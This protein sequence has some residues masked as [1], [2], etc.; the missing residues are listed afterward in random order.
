MKKLISSLSYSVRNKAINICLLPFALMFSTVSITASA[1]TNGLW[2]KQFHALA[3]YYDS[4]CQGK[5][6]KLSDIN[7]NDSPEVKKVSSN[8]TIGNND[9]GVCTEYFAEYFGGELFIS[10]EENIT[11]YLKSDDGSQLFINGNLLINNDNTHDDSNE[12]N[13]SIT[14][15]VGWHFIEV[16]YFNSGGG[17]SLAVSYSSATISKQ[18]IPSSVL[19]PDGAYDPDD[20]GVSNY[21]DLDVDG[22]GLIE[23]STLAELD[24]VRNNLAGAALFGKSDGCGAA[25]IGFELTKDLDFDTSGDGVVGANDDY[26]NAGDGWLP[27]GRKSNSAFKAIFEGNSFTINNLNINRGQEDGVGFF[28]FARGGA[29][30]QNLDLTNTRVIGKN[31]VGALVGKADNTTFNNVFSTGHVSGSNDVGGLIGWANTVAITTVHHIGYISGFGERVGGIVGNLANN[32]SIE[33]AFNIGSVKGG[34]RVGGITGTSDSAI[35]DVYVAGYVNGDQ[36]VGGITSGISSAHLARSYVVAQVTGNFDTGAILG[37]IFAPDASISSSYWLTGIAESA[38]FY[39]RNVPITITEANLVDL[40]CPTNAGDNSCN[41]I[42]YADWD[43]STPIWQFGTNN[44]LPALM[45]NGTVYFLADFD[46]D[47]V[48]DQLDAFPSI[49]IGALLD[50]D[51][52]GIPDDCDANCLSSGLIADV[53]DDNDG[54]DDDSDAFPFDASEFTDNDSDGTGDNADLDDDNDGVNDDQDE[55]PLDAAESSDTDGDG[56]GDNAD[57]DDDNDGYIDSKDSA[58]LNS[59]LPGLT[60]IRQQSGDNADIRFAQAIANIGDV[61]GDGVNDLAISAHE[62]DSNGFDNSGS[63]HVMS[64]KTGQILYKIYGEGE[65]DKLAEAMISAPDMDGD[66]I[67]DFLVRRRGTNGDELESVELFSSKAGTS[68]FTIAIPNDLNVNKLA[69]IDDLNGDGIADILVTLPGF[70]NVQNNIGAVYIYSGADGSELSHIEGEGGYFGDEIAVLG[71]IND[72]L[73]ADFI[74]SAASF[75]GQNDREGRI[76]AYSGA[77]NQL[78]YQVGGQETNQEIGEEMVAIGDIDNDGINDFVYSNRTKLTVNGEERRFITFASGKDGNQIEQL[79]AGNYSLGGFADQLYSISDIDGDGSIDLVITDEGDD[80]SGSV[81]D[82]IFYSTSKKHIIG[83]INNKNILSRGSFAE[84]LLVIDDITGDN[85]SEIVVGDYLHDGQASNAG[86]IF[87]Y[88]FGDFVVDTDGDG[89]VNGDDADID[90]DGVTNFNDAYPYISLAG[91]TDSDLDGIP[92][93]CDSECQ[94]SGMVTDNYING[95]IYVDSSSSC[96]AANEVC[97]QSWQSPFRTLQDALVVANTNQQIWLAQGLY[98]PNESDNNVFNNDLVAFKLPSNVSLYGGFNAA[99][100]PTLLTEAD[101]HKF[102]TILSGDVDHLSSPDLTD[103]LGITQTVTDIIGDNASV[104]IFTAL[105]SQDYTIAGLTLTGVSRMQSNQYAL[106]ISSGNATVKNIDIIGSKSSINLRENINCQIEMNNINLI[107]ITTGSPLVKIFDTQCQKITISDLSTTNAYT[108]D[109]MF[110]VRGGDNNIEFN[111]ISVINENRS[112]ERLLYTTSDQSNLTVTINDSVFKNI[113]EVKSQN[114]L[115]V[116]NSIFMQTHGIEQAED[117]PLTVKHSS[118]INNKSTNDAGAISSTSS[119]NNLGFNLFVGN[120]GTKANNIY[121]VNDVNDLGYNLV[122]ANSL[123]GFVSQTGLSFVQAFDSATS[124]TS[125]LTIEQITEQTLADNGGNILT[126]LPTLQGPAVDVISESDCHQEFDIRGISR[127][128]E[129]L[130]DIGAVEFSISDLDTD[131]DGVDDSSDAFPLDPNETTDTDA[132]GVGNNADT[133]DDGDGYP[134]EG[135]EFP[136]NPLEWLDTDFDGVGNNADTDDDGDGIPDEQDGSPLDNNIGDIAA[137][138]IYLLGNSSINVMVNQDYVEPGFSALD[139]VDGDLSGSVEISGT[140]DSSIVGTYIISYNVIDAA[141][142]AAITK[143]RQVTVQDVS[144]P[145]VI[146]PNNIIIA[147][148]DAFGTPI[149]NTEINAFLNSANA[150]DDVD[151]SLAVVYDAPNIFPLGVTTVYFTAIDSA[152]NVGSAQAT[153]TVTDL[154]AP[155]LSLVG[156]TSITLSLNET[157]S[158]LGYSAIDNVDGDISANVVVNG[159]VDSS[160]LGTYIISYKI[161]DAAGNFTATQNR[162]VTVQDAA[163]PVIISPINIIVAAVDANGTLD[164]DIDIN[165]FLSAA[166][167]SDNVDT[168][169]AVS[170]DAPSLFPLGIT[171]I[172]F[173][174]TD[175]S[176]NLGTARATVTIIDQSAP[177]LTLLGSTSAILGWNE[178]YI[179]AGYS[180]IDNVD[181]DLSNNVIVA[182]SVDSS[183]VGTYLLSYNVSDSA[184]NPGQTRNRQVTVQKII[185]QDSDGDGFA[186]EI[187]DFP[188]DVTEWLDSDNDGMGNNADSDDDNDSVEDSSDAFPLDPAESVDTDG[189][190]IGNNADTDDDN[191]G[192]LDDED[193][194]PLV[195]FVDTQAPVFAELE[196][197]IFEAKGEVTIVELPSPSVTDNSTESPTV[198]SNLSEGLTIGTHSV[199]WT[200]IDGV[201]NQST[202]IQAVVIIDSTAPVFTT[203]EA[204]TVNAEGRLT[205]VYYLVNAI[206]VDIVDGDVLVTTFENTMLPSGFHELQIVA[207]DMAGNESIATV[208]VTIYPEAS[209]RNTL[210]VES[211]GVYNIDVNLSGDAPNYPVSISYQLSLNGEQLETDSLIIDEGTTGKL[212]LLIPTALQTA[213]NLVLHLAEVDNVFVGD[214]SQSQLILVEGNIAPLLSFTMSQN[215]QLVSVIDPDKGEVTFALQISDVNFNDEH[216]ITWTDA[217]G[218]FANAVDVLT[219]HLE[220]STLEQGTYNF[221]VSVVENNTQESLS[222]TKTVRFVVEQ[223]AELVSS[224]DSDHDGINDSDEGYS[225]SDG[226]GIADYLDNDSNTTR[227][228][229]SENT[230]PMQTTA[231]LIMSL[232]SLVS[233]QGVTSNEASLSVDDLAQLVGD[234]AAET[235]DEGVLAVTPLYNFTIDGLTEQGSSV[236]VVIPMAVDTF[237]PA[238]AIYRKYNERDGWFTFV[239]D[240]NN[241]ISS[242]HTDINGNCPAANDESYVLGLNQGDNCFQLIIE[243]GGPN[244]VD[245]I[246]NGSVEDPGAIVIDAVNHAPVVVITTPEYGYAEETSFSLTAQANDEDGDE[247]TYLWQQV[248]GPEVVFDDAT[249]AMVNVSLPEVILDELIEIQVTVSDGELSTTSVTS[250]RV[251]SVIDGESEALAERLNAGTTFWLLILLV[252]VRMR[253][254][255]NYLHAA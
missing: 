104:I 72:D 35:S 117:F 246:I 250:F 90:N 18:I 215:D 141:S 245:L 157:Y 58:P 74:V 54:V 59:L 155:A 106:N 91:L 209:I 142:N 171:T 41:Q 37:S 97:G 114:I 235:H 236:A 78:L 22:D 4:E 24:E 21:W 69:F 32:S 201:G 28:G 83:R 190:N 230:E 99:A 229:S 178:T 170:H 161:K 166:S 156:N 92:D 189:D 184:G 239:E 44:Q 227:L 128:Q 212:S 193:D 168:D 52:D 120:T 251:V 40:S 182:G 255:R 163:A 203:V 75:D 67:A 70:D 148:I 143:T 51:N 36:R 109:S 144:A 217:S 173:S 208:P 129:S 43:D 243:D 225:D 13:N 1:D 19:R 42:F 223:L 228:P 110:E 234:N 160:T 3:S 194:K 7:F 135:D 30:I 116:N 25:C 196:Q 48:S 219:Y 145:V 152:N 124:F 71:D 207:T 238:G 60:P 233:S 33:N 98:Y 200:A 133:D 187:D 14:L 77:D 146:A 103:N 86:A 205:D 82:I 244:D 62:D 111:R 167:A 121:V 159:V 68:L 47:G 179:E 174:A 218:T 162:Q 214:T 89:T 64:A 175:S 45:Q 127:P 188:S 8:F 202:A 149:S 191:D 232:G 204:I 252:L 85:F 15:G 56:I 192:I 11:F 81:R 241:N 29:N 122:G 39:G 164:S 76:Y 102:K 231:G 130:C 221:E 220:P 140:V 23:I 150:N 247:L 131:G 240:E 49:A 10:A 197:L 73:I 6:T 26:W 199:T 134:D 50:N 100:N 210:L 55:F 181:G 176:G 27:I 94:Q 147:T 180:V 249:F 84:S 213:D 254:V 216:D 237:L 211:G 16:K 93:S 137:P 108:D 138:I 206:A 65:D 123:N 87:T 139:N 95:V 242:A 2:N 53:D 248:S 61:D 38:V 198:T 107:N 253:K 80:G 5:P 195:A 63:V 57:V 101:P 115:N 183:T 112:S 12:L 119:T 31:G 17:H 125:A 154:D 186:D 224:S 126:V 165:D 222:V 132:D 88:S 20:D 226:D 177:V 118:F 151:G 79:I 113:G 34:D 136:L 96:D 66:N 169:I 172:T 105:G 46:G 153:V 185:G 9:S 158:E